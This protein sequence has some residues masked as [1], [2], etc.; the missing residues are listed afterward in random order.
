MTKN[1]QKLLTAL[2]G[3]VQTNSLPVI[4]HNINILIISEVM[5]ND[6]WMEG[7]G[8]SKRSVRDGQ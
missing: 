5:G 7:A 8:V 2:I 3:C 6:D 1:E 4:Q